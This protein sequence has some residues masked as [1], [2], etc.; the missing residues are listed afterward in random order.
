MK[1]SDLFPPG[2]KKWGKPAHANVIVYL[3]LKGYEKCMKLIMSCL[4]AANPQYK[5]V[6]CPA[7]S[8]LIYNRRLHESDMCKCVICEQPKKKKK[9][10]E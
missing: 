5:G 7:E 6:L 8:S 3:M 9:K 2:G 1:G 10:Y 4:M